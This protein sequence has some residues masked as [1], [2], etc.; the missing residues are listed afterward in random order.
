M[1]DSLFP[2]SE[3]E[4]PE[5]SFSTASYESRSKPKLVLAPARSLSYNKRGDYWAADE[6]ERNALRRRAELVEFVLFRNGPPLS[7]GARSS[8][9]WCRVSV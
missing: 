5:N 7:T 9:E 8:P 4:T 3:S 2:V 6:A 1:T